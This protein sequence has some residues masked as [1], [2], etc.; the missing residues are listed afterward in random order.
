MSV[1]GVG[2]RVLPLVR[3]QRRVEQVVR[4]LLAPLLPPGLLGRRAAPT[5]LL[6]YLERN[7]FSILFL[8]IYQALGIPE[9]RRLFYGSLNHALRGIVTGADNLLDDEYKELLPLALPERAVRFK[10]VLHLL[11]FDRC[12]SAAVAGAADRGLLGPHDPAALNA[13]IF[14]ALLAV[15]GQEAAEEG[16][17]AGILPPGEL[18][19]TVHARRGGDLLRL[20]LVAPRYLERERGPALALADDG[21]YRIGMALQVLDDV[22]DVVEDL[23]RGHHNY[24]VSSVWHE[25]PAAE[26]ERLDALRRAP[27]APERLDAVFPD[28]LARVAG[29]AVT[30]ALAGFAVLERAGLW[31]DPEGARWVVGQLFRLRGLGWLWR[32]ALANGGRA[33]ALTE[34]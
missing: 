17:V 30:E 13:R 29:R 10:S 23:A 9:E 18:L 25:G 14:A 6:G 27:A 3:E 31:L 12:L 32:R 2:R 34:T 33:G 7:A 20:A 28:G 26:R 16:G 5:G 4:D 11:F 24:L 21:V 1:L 15:G 19:A 22:T 8:A